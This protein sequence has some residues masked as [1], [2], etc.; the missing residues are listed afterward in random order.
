MQPSERLKRGAPN[1]MDL[2]FLQPCLWLLLRLPSQW[3]CNSSGAMHMRLGQSAMYMQWGFDSGGR[4]ICI[5][6]TDV[7]FFRLFIW[8]HRWCLFDYVDVGGCGLGS[9]GSAR[10]SLHNSLCNEP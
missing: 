8:A 5:S 1:R 3:H 6:V 4:W 9:F 7:F 10:G 2:I